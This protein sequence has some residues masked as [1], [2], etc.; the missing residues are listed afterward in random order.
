[1][2]ESVTTGTVDEV[3]HLYNANQA[4]I[5]GAVSI[6]PSSRDATKFALATD[7]IEGAREINNALHVSGS[8]SFW[9]ASA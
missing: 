1:M 9:Q 2:Y 5:P 7:N 8:P 4:A 3:L 6:L